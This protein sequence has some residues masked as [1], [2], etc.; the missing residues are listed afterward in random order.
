MISATV[1]PASRVPP[2]S[3]S[4]PDWS[5]E[6]AHTWEHHPQPTMP[7]PRLNQ[8]AISR[9]VRPYTRRKDLP[10]LILRNQ[11]SEGEGTRGYYPTRPLLAR[12][13][14]CTHGRR[15]RGIRVLRQEK[16][17]QTGSLM[18]NICKAEAVLGNHEPVRAIDP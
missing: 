10:T 15:Q 4:A 8:Q 18:V 16:L 11:V 7:P 2:P 17:L 12:V 3:R 1:L 9:G 6:R 5:S 13:R 14:C